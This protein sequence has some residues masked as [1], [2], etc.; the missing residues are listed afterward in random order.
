[1][2][3]SLLREISNCPVLQGGD[4]GNKR[5]S[6]LAIMLA[7]AAIR[8]YLFPALKDGAITSDKQKLMQGWYSCSKS[9]VVLRLKSS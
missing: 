9:S 2:P 8:C 7:K 5:Y 1:M 6:A 4:N 3:W